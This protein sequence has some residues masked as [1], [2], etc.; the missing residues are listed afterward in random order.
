LAGRRQSVLRPIEIEED[1]FADALLQAALFGEQRIFDPAKGSSKKVNGHALVLEQDRGSA[2]VSLDEQ[3]GILITLPIERSGR[4]H[5]LPALIQEDVER[6]LAAALAYAGW[7]LERIDPTQR[8]THVAIA[9]KIAEGDSLAWRTQRE[10]DASPN[11]VSYGHGFHNDERAPVHL[12]PSHRA[13]A[14]LMLDR[15]R[16]VEDLVVLLRRQWR[17]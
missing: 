14:A 6:Q 11:H 16:L 5:G 1:A 3:G 2:T 7:L 10:H 13:R 9:G 8:L 12:Q 4:G 17:G 15:P